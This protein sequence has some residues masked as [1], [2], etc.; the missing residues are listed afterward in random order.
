MFRANFESAAERA[1]KHHFAQTLFEAFC[2][3]GM[4]RALAIEDA[5]AHADAQYLVRGL[6]SPEDEARSSLLWI[7]D[8]EA[9]LHA[10]GTDT[11]TQSQ[12]N[13]THPK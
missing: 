8:E 1:W 5:Y 3:S 6:K 9:G 11:T 10:T 4:E 2:A 12:S 7:R 13:G